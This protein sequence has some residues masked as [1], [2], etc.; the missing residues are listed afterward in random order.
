MSDLSELAEKYAR[1][2][3]N[4]GDLQRTLEL[5]EANKR[6]EERE[7]DVTAEKLR[8]A[9][10]PQK[11]E[12]LIPIGHRRHVYVHTAHGVFSGQYVDIDIIEEER[13]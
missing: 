12:L 13:F 5:A 11:R 1:Q 6:R 3:A 9:I 8:N 10:T 7:L 4:V 2:L